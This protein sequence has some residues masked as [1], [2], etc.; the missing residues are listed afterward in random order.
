M[1][2]AC[3]LCESLNLT[4]CQTDRPLSVLASDHRIDFD[5]RR[6]TGYGNIKTRVPSHRPN[7]ISTKRLTNAKQY[8]PGFLK[9]GIIK[10]RGMY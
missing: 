3:A 10:A 1:L 8:I 4:C 2:Q 9:L 7:Y 5:D 6:S